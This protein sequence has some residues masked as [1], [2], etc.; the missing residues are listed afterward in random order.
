MKVTTISADYT[1]DACESETET[2]TG[3]L[4]DG[5]IGKV[6]SRLSDLRIPIRRSIHIGPVCKASTDPAIIA[7]IKVLLLG[8]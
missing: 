8:E 3:S 2:T 7:A 5:W 4:P 1:C 6:V